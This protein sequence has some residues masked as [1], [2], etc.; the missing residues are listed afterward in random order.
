MH[1]TCVRHT[2]LPHTTPLFADV[3]YHPD[4]TAPF[5]RHPVRDLEAYHAAAA[6][7]DSPRPSAAALVAALRVQNPDGPS[8]E[9]LAQ[10]GTVAVV[11]GQ[12]VGLFS[13]PAYTIYKA[14]HAA[15][16]AEWLTANGIPAVPV[17]WLATEDHDFAEVNH[18]WVFDGEHRPVKLEMRR[19]ASAQ[20]VGDVALAAPPVGELRTACAACRSAKKSPTSWKRPIARG[21][22]MGK[23]FGELLRDLLARY[24][25]LQVDPMLPEFRGWPRRRCA[26]PWSGAGTERTRAGAQPGTDRRRLPRPGARGRADVVGV[27]AGERQAPGAAAPRREYVLNGRRFTAAELM[28][29]AADAF[30]ERAAAARGAGFHAAHRGLHR[31]SGGNGLPGANRDD[32]PRPAGPHAGGGAAQRFHH[33]G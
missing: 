6:R 18:A 12:Q 9:R 1:C 19:T 15:K 31:R 16:L 2:E 11:T 8:L 32:L 3:L 26:A 29:R 23:A 25:I 30:A 33:S 22:T 14:L 24:D 28:D 5:Y 10:P 17:F 4:R 21:S 7:F 27:P 13:G 20:P